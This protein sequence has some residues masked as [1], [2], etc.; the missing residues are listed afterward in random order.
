MSCR[1]AR[2]V[3]PGRRAAAWATRMETGGTGLPEPQLSGHGPPPCCASS[4]SSPS[5][6]Y[7]LLAAGD[8][9]RPPSISIIPAA[10]AFSSSTQ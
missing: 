7:R 10:R 1:S 6:S 5:R 3:K 9:G 4:R 2:S 8:T